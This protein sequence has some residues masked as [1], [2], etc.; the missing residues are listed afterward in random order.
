MV[1]D[2]SA[3]IAILTNEPE[4]PKLAQAIQSDAVRLLSA[5]SLLETAIVIEARYGII[6]GEK[7]DELLQ[8]A[9][10]AIE[11]ITAE[12]A[13]IARIAYRNYGKGIHPAGLNFGDC[14]A[15]ALARQSGQ[16]LLFKGDDFAKTDIPA[17]L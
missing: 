8:V 6:G 14:F 13:N 9:Q 10:V 2:T 12:H 15:Y 7:L 1:I 11:P 3:I 4:A 16:P 5:A 17:A